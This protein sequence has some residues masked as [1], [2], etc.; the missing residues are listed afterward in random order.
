[1]RESADRRERTNLSRRLHT[2]RK[3]T[4]RKLTLRRS[5]T[6]TMV[7]ND[8]ATKLVRD[9]V[10][11][12]D[13]AQ[14]ETLRKRTYGDPQKKLGPAIKYAFTALHGSL[15]HMSYAASR[16]SQEHPQLPALPPTGVYSHAKTNP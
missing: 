5:L 11:A 9:I 3:L 2:D 7:P 14:L 13:R 1:M 10:Y 16:L 6:S 12:C 15:P 8:V 4:P